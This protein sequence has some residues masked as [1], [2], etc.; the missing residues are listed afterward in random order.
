M[1][2]RGAWIEI[3]TDVFDC[4][5][6]RV[7]R[8][9]K[10]PVTTLI[11]TLGIEKDEDI[12]KMFGDNQKIINTLEK[13]QI[14]DS[15]EAMIEIYKKL[16]PGELP[17]YEAARN[18]L[19]QLLFNDRRY[20]LSTVGRYKYNQKLALASRISRRIACEDVVDP[21]TGEVFVKNGEKITYEQAVE[22]QDSG[23]NIVKVKGNDGKTVTVIGNGTVNIKKFVD[24]KI[25]D[26]L[27]ITELVNYLELKAILDTTAKKDL[28]E[29]L[30]ENIDK[31]VPKHVLV[32]DIFAAISYIIN[33]DNGIGRIDNID[34]LGNR[35]LRSVGELLEN[36]FRIGLVR[37]ERVVRERMS[38]QDLDAITPQTLINTKP[39]TSVMKEF[40]GS[41]QLSQFMDQTNPLSEL[42]HKR[43]ISALGPRRIIT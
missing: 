42:T 1:P 25:V 13:D 2:L 22:I 7:D 19:T 40:F 9:R 37:L 14:K 31:L 29:K 16:R 15:Q 27:K 6:A 26:E 36:Q 11:R 24:E 17:T 28:K 20:D 35:R 39:I 12:L 8:T 18:L 4:V 38:V 10:I 23:I 32:E 34:H 5:Y 33:L 21:E 43:R 41:S 30:K 3:E